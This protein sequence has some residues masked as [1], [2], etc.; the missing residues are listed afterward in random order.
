MIK[1]V[2]LESPLFLALD[3]DDPKEA[4]KLAQELRPYVGGY[5]VGPRLVMRYGA[6]FVE[7]LVAM[8]PVFVDMKFFDIPNT[9][10]TSLQAVFDMGA[11]FATIHTLAGPE[12]MSRM[13]ELQKRLSQIR[14]FQILGVTLLTSL[15][16]KNLPPGLTT[17]PVSEQVVA[18]ATM[19]Q[20]NGI[21]GFVCSAEEIEA[22]RKVTPN[23]FV[24]TPGIRMT[25]ESTQDQ[26]RVNGPVEALAKG[27]SALVVGRPIV[28]AKNPLEVAKTY[29]QTIRNASVL[30]KK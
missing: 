6:S 7:Q 25:G 9:M 14:P 10:E 24:V 20:N 22:V 18:L 23:G 28:D 4:L 12:A 27:S 5:K 16:A 15:N 17:V 13:A 29:Y 21:N 11:T 3:I 30:K 2:E 26:Q 19:A 8:R 1:N